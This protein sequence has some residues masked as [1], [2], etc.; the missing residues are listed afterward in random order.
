MGFN[1]FTN[2][3]VKQATRVNS[4]PR[5]RPAAQAGI[6]AVNA[7]AARDATNAFDDIEGLL[8]GKSTA[9]PAR[10]VS[11]DDLCA[12]IVPPNQIPSQAQT[13]IAVSVSPNS[14]DDGSNLASVPGIIAV[15]AFVSTVPFVNVAQYNTQRTRLVIQNLG[16]GNLFVIFGKAAQYGG[17]ITTNYH[18]QVASGQVYFDDQW[19]GRIDVASD[20]GCSISVVELARAVN[21]SQ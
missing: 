3:S 14:W 19:Q 13:S 17:N 5:G 8:E 12:A 20:S 16:S 6:D 1:D 15:P 10:G 11:L 9:R 4:A 21:V 7:S 2:N 18:L